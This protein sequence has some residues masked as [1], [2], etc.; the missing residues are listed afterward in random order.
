MDELGSWADEG[1]PKTGKK[2][3]KGQQREVQS[4]DDA[5]PANSKNKKIKGKQKDD[6][7]DESW[8]DGPAEIAPQKKRKGKKGKKKGRQAY[9]ENDDLD[10]VA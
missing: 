7:A 1:P 3:K 10:E 8:M 4:E 9:S 2:G 6:V 5:L